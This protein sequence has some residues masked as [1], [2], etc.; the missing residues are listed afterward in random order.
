MIVEITENYSC[1]TVIEIVRFFEVRV[2]RIIHR[3]VICTI[4]RLDSKYF[5]LTVVTGSCA[6]LTIGPGLGYIAL[7][8]YEIRR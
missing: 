1:I 5:D 7:T 3:G 8:R 6:L 2:W 4:T